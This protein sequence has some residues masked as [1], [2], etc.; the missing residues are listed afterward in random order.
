M[1]LTKACEDNDLAAVNRLLQDP[2]VNPAAN[3]NAAIE[4]ASRGGHL[5]V[6]ERLLQDERVD[7]SARSNKAIIDASQYGHLAIVKRLIQDKRVDP[8]NRKTPQ[9]DMQLS[10]T[11]QLLSSVCCRTS[12]SIHAHCIQL[13]TTMLLCNILSPH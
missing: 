9:F 12:V 13:H 4:E 10:V 11:T 6:L 3:D 7:P 8:S 1:A 5:A 2:R